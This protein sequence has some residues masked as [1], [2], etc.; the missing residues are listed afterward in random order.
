MFKV[1][2]VFNV[3]N[4]IS[5]TIEGK[6]EKIKNGSILCDAEGNRYTVVSVGMTRHN[7]PHD[8]SKSTT[9]LVVPCT[10][11]NGGELYLS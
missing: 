9:I 8:I 1:T 2:D 3:G 5:A 6:C 4:M 10:L 7:N 11:K